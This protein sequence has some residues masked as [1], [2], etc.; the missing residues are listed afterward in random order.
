MGR[1]AGQSTSEINKTYI[2]N[3]TGTQSWI[4]GIT[5]MKPG[6]VMYILGNRTSGNLTHLQ[7]GIP[8]KYWVNTTEPGNTFFLEV[9]YKN[10]MISRNEVLIEG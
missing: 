5:S 6:E 8:K 3:S 2:T 10:T 7:E 4:N 9:Y 1:S